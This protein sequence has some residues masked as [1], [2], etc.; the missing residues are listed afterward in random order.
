[1][2]RAF[3]IVMDSFG[4]GGAPDAAEYYNGEHSDDG[5]ATFQHI[6]EA[7]AQG[8]CDTK[9]RSGPLRVPN[10]KKMGIGHAAHQATGEWPDGFSEE[11]DLIGRA[12]AATEVS[13]GKDTISG[14][15]EI[16]GV[17]VPFD[18][19][20][21]PKTIPTLPDDVRDGMIAAANL[22]GILADRHAEGLG[23]IEEFGQEHI[24]SGKPIVYTSADSVIQIAAH[25]K[26]FGLE[27]LYDL[28]EA[29]RKLADKYKIGRVIARPFL[30]ENPET[31]ERT[32][33]RRDYSVPP[34][35]P[36]VLDRLEGAGHAVRAIGKV[37]DIFAHRGVTDTRKVSGHPALMEET[38]KALDELPDGGFAFINFVD[39]DQLYGH[40]RNPAGYAAAL[41]WFDARLPE[42]LGG[43]RPDDLLIITADHGNDPTW[44]GTDHTR[45]RVPVLMTGAETAPG[46]AV[47]R[48]TFADIGET[49]ASHLRI[50]NGTHGQPIGR[51]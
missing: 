20:Y 48:E 36:T 50:P 21:L 16:G 34:P 41:E 42:I 26:H 5:A 51:V 22:P 17:P 9:D 24:E 13:K 4:I 8:R 45:E 3:L 18:W 31:F 11:T 40:R 1:M 29:T 14:H 19:G 25:E 38:L 46:L 23:V 43:L 7:C 2:A 49:I 12:C 39:F 6:A 27:R 44:T 15:W 35:E 47:M 28:C 10:L 37:A 33:N 30:G 32:G